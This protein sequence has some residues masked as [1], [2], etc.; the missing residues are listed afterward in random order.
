MPLRSVRF[1]FRMINPA[2][3]QRLAFDKKT[4]DVVEIVPY[5]KHNGV[6]VKGHNRMPPRKRR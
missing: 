3:K 4:N 6:W 1:R 5:F 2:F